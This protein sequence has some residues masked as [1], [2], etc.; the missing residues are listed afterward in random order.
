MPTQTRR[1][2]R[3]RAVALL[4]AVALM[5]QVAPALAA[6][7]ETAPVTPRVVV[8]TVLAVAPNAAGNATGTFQGSGTSL[9]W[10]AEVMGG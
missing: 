9:S 6:R 10:W 3:A 4:G 7:A 8:S 5:A 2:L 1:R